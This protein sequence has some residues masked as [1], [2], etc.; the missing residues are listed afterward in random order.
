V[1]AIW[2]PV[3]SHFHCI[4]LA[5]IRSTLNWR[6]SACSCIEVISDCIGRED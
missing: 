2:I 5:F 4:V 6:L 3:S 1:V